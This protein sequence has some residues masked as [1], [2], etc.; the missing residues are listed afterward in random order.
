MLLFTGHMQLTVDDRIKLKSN[1]ELTITNVTAEDDGTYVCSVGVNED[2]VPELQ[3]VV[4]VQCE[5]R[6][7]AV[8]H[9]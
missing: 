5:Y 8:V 6:A 3:H 4:S 2:S 7:R 9:H 1:N